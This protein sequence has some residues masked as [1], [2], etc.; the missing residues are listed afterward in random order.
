M[1]NKENIICNMRNMVFLNF[2]ELTS[3]QKNP[4]NS[5]KIRLFIVRFKKSCF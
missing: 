1:L 5:I 4:K 3:G 2:F